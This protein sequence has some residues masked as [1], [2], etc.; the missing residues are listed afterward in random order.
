MKRNAKTPQRLERHVFVHVKLAGT[1]A[2]LGYGKF[3]ASV[4]RNGVGD[5]TLTLVNPS[6]QL[7]QAQAT[8]YVADRTVCVSDRTATTVRLLVTDHTNTAQDSDFGVQIIC[9]DGTD[10]Y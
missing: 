6:T 5:Y 10:Q 9:N 2:S 8:G 3:Q 4:V 7:V 1:V